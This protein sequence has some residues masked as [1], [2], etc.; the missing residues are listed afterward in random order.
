MPQA[1]GN[2]VRVRQRSLL[3]VSI[4]TGFGVTGYRKLFLE[5]VP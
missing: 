3:E 2:F 5:V 1:G 4:E